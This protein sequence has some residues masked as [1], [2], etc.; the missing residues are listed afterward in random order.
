MNSREALK[1]GLDSAEYI[2]MA[3]IQDLSDEDLMKRPHPACNHINWQLGHL[4]SSEHQ[5]TNDAVPNSMP[6]LPAGFAEKYTK[7][8][9]ASN[10][11]ARFAKK[12]EL[13]RVYREQRAGTLAVL[14]KIDDAALDRPT[15]LD[16]A[17][18]VGAIFSLHGGHWLMH[19]GQWVIVRRALGRPALF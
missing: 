19:A 13:L 15:G 2:A 16:Y 8:T 14:Q 17:Q 6:A 7:E 1:L 10:D 12:E 4:I 9:A 5:M 18:N 3:Y 11:P